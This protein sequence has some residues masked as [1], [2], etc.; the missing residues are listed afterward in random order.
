MATHSSVLT[1]RIPRTEKPGVTVPR[2]AES[3][4]TE[5]T[6]DARIVSLKLWSRIS[7]VHSTSTHGMPT[8]C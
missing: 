7:F 5:G 6:Q 4:M 1:W 8:T 2:V 3:D